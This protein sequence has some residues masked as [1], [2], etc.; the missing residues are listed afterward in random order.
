MSKT[1]TWSNGQARLS[2]LMP[3]EKNPVQLS[4]RA[5][6]KLAEQLKRGQDL[7]Y[8]IAAPLNG[9]SKLALLD[10]HQRRA[11]ELSINHTDPNKI[12]RIIYPSRALTDKEK[13]R[14][15]IEHRKN[16]GEFD[17]DALLNWYD[18]GELLEW[19]FEQKEI[20]IIGFDFFSGDFDMSKLPQED[21]IPFQ[22]MTFTLHDTQVKNVLDAL[23]AA[24]KK[25]AFV[26]SPNENSNGNSLNRI[27]MEFLKIYAN[28]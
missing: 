23:A 21:R 9:K 24:K 27:C 16:T 2:D 11:V 13:Q 3:F 15:I 20:M 18:G 17:N 6:K 25:G 26:K 1:I 19:G 5:A 28:R 10:G 8:V 12:V 14:W 7:P 22:Q 4:E